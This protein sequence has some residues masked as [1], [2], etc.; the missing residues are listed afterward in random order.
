[1]GNDTLNGQPATIANTDVTPVTTGPLS[2]DA[3]GN[4]TVAPNTPSG[5]YTITYNLCE[6]G[7]TPAGSNCNDAIATVVVANPIVANDDT[8]ATPVN[9]STGG[10]AIQTVLSNDTLNGVLV[11][12]SQVTITLTSTLPTGIVFNTNTG[13]VSVLAGTPAGSYTFTYNLCEVGSNPL[14]CDPATVIVNVLNIQAV[15]DAT[16]TISGSN[17]GITPSVFLNDTLNGVPFLPS[18][19]LFTILGPAIPGF[20]VNPNGTFTVAPNTLAGSYNINYQICDALNPSTCSNA[21]IVIIIS[22]NPRISLVKTATFNDEMNGD[23]FAQVGESITY[24]FVITNTGNVPLSNVIVTDNLA[25]VVVSGGPILTLGVGQSDE[26]TYTANYFIQQSDINF[27]SVSNQALVNGVSPGG[28]NA[29]DLSDNDNNSENEPTILELVG[30]VVEVFNAVSPDG[31]GL[32]DIFYI[33]GLEC[34]TDNTVEIYNRWGVLVFEKIGYDNSI[35]TSFKGVSEGRV[36]VK[37]GDN[38]P[39]G[40][41]FYILK[42]K[43]F[44]NNQLQKAG[45]L[46]INR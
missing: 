16:V 26:D 21:F 30:C 33:R 22:E 17:G 46:Y 3:D 4:L 41:Y 35:N 32:N 10:I 20:T 23:G 6:A 12:S 31:D 11:N 5:T 15:D 2:I 1:M 13:A 40:T 39:E 7:T 8:S 38:L 29:Q 34:F 19:V 14:N 43:D 9:G 45:Y 24:N 18:Q 36:T 25:G 37:Q 27:G 44:G 42:Y 28:V